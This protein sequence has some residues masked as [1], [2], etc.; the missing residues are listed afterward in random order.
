M[1]EPV[2]KRAQE[3]Q[4][5]KCGLTS[6]G[7][8]LYMVCVGKPQ[9]AAGEAAPTVTYLEGAAHG[10]RDGAAPRACHLE[11]AAR[12]FHHRSP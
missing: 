4:V 10:R 9:A 8:V 11:A 12:S 1:N 7:P 5:L 2:M 3:E 6:I